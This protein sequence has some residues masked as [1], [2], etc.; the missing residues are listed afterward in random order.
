MNSIKIKKSHIRIAFLTIWL[1]VSIFFTYMLYIKYE[2][3]QVPK[4][5]L[6]FRDIV[7]FFTA[8]IVCGTLIFHVINIELN[9]TSNE[10]KLSIDKEKLAFDKAKLQHD[11]KVLS[12]QLIGEWG[13]K[14][15][16][17]HATEAK[18]FA[19]VI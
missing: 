19:D 14:D 6:E 10:K 13:R 8:C 7:A 11:K 15:I 18:K 16:V 1:L 5:P 4:Q 2:T 9:N 12:S 17:E 3:A